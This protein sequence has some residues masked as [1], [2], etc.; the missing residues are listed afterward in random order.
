MERDCTTAFGGD[1][2]GFAGDDGVDQRDDGGGGGDR[3]AVDDGFG[4][5]VVGDVGFGQGEGVVAFIEGGTAFFFAELDVVRNGTVGEAAAELGDVCLNVGQDVGVGEQVGLA[6]KR[7]QL[8][9]CDTAFIEAEA[10]EV[11]QQVGGIVAFAC[12]VG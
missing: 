3:A 10:Q 6:V 1:P 12:E 4:D 11:D 7:G 2:V 9:G 8:G 5:G